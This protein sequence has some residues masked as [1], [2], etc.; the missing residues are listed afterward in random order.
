MFGFQ[1]IGDLIWAAADMR[2][3]GFLIGATAGRTTLSGEG[4]Q[5]QDGHSHLHASTVPNLIAYDPAFEFEITSIVL[6]GIRRMY[7][8][9]EDVFYYLTVENEKYPMPP[10]PEG[11]E[12]G[13]LKGMYCF[14]PAA[15]K[16]R[17][18]RPH[19]NLLGSGA[20]MRETLRAAEL[21]GERFGV[22]ADV[23]SVT[24]YKEL[25]REALACDRWSRLHPMAPP[26]KSYVAEQFEKMNGPV[27]AASDYMKALPDSI[28]PWAPEGIVSLGTDGFGRSGTRPELR[29]FFEVDAE[30]IALAA[31]DALAKRGEFERSAVQEAIKDLGIDP[32]KAD[33]LTV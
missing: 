12:E 28:A 31:L 5:H 2:T 4:L 23:W 22:A 13:V 6:D 16:G 10:M 15:N 33:P 19:V 9:G 21:L 20:I 30:C 8:E 27:V 14:R 25:R 29:R 7:Q 1:R 26:R 3:K 11:V 32:E 17:A 24:S 18:K